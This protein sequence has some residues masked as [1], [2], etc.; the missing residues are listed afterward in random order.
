[1][2]TRELHVDPKHRWREWFAGRGADCYARVV[3]QLQ[4]Y[5]L[6]KQNRGW[7]NIQIYPEVLF[8]TEASVVILIMNV[9]IFF[10]AW[11]EGHARVW[12]KPWGWL[13][14]W[15]G[16]VHK[17]SKKQFNA[18]LKII[19]SIVVKAV[20]GL[21]LAEPRQSNDTLDDGVTPP[22][23]GEMSSSFGRYQVA[24]T[25]L[26]AVLVSL[27]LMFYTLMFEGLISKS[28][29][30]LW[31]NAGGSRGNKWMISTPGRFY[32]ASG[33]YCAVIVIA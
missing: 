17:C 11:E 20:V 2:H 32:A 24:E 25:R 6:G 21:S 19:F 9:I 10:R 18:I 1:M 27:R 15:R 4:I 22:G 31:W 14:L 30:L 7:V 29:L 3:T 16:V 8:S 26:M 13:L 23:R 33:R 5:W 28:V 12:R